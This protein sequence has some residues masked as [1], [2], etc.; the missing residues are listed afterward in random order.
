MKRRWRRSG[1]HGSKG[2]DTEGYA[3]PATA[4]ARTTRGRRRPSGGLISSNAVRSAALT[5]TDVLKE[6]PRDFEV[7]EEELKVELL[8]RGMRNRHRQS[9][10][11]GIA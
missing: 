1:G 6:T 11:P 10:G 8:S 5:V 4:P 2:I 9:L 7:G 3:L